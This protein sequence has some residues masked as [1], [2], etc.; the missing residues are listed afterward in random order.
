MTRLQPDQGRNASS[1]WNFCACF[2]KSFRCPGNQYWCSGISAV[3]SVYPIL[4]LC[5][6]ISSA[7]FICSSSSPSILPFSFLFFS[8]S[9]S[10][11]FSSHPPLHSSFLPPLSS[12]IHWHII[13]SLLITFPFL[14]LS[15]TSSPPL[16]YL[17]QAAFS[18]WRTFVVMEAAFSIWCTFVVMLCNRL[19]VHDAPPRCFWLANYDSMHRF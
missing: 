13:P 7:F 10:L 4:L 8:S 1:V 14:I 16:P 12:L 17:S 9:H 11:F 2:S 6:H 3:F 18:I 5:G 19:Q 15:I